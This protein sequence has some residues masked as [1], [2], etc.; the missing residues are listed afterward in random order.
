MKNSICVPGHSFV[1]GFL[2]LQK[3]LLLE[4]SATHATIA[5]LIQKFVIEERK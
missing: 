5:L 3:W 2:G 1:T 4:I